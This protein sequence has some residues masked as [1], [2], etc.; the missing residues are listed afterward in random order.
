MHRVRVA[1]RAAPGART[2][3]PRPRAAAVDRIADQRMAD[4]L[5]VDA[6][7]VRAPGFEAAFDQAP[8]LRRSARARGSW[9]APPCRAASTA[10]RVRAPGRGRSARRSRR[11]PAARRAPARGRCASRC[12]R[13]AAHE[14]GLRGRGSSRPP[15]GRSC[16]CPADARC[17]RA[18]PGAAP[19]RACSSAFSSV[20]SGLPAPGCTTS[21]AGLSM[22]IRS[23]SSY[24]IVERHALRRR[25]RARRR[26]RRRERDLLAAHGLRAR[27][28]RCAPSTRTWPGL[29]PCLQP[30][31]RILRETARQR[32][33]QAQAGELRAGTAQ[34]SSAHRQYNFAP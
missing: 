17:R 12:A 2:R 22:T 9:C 34:P 31:A 16:P 21:P 30:A 13:R 33:V 10:M 5:Q 6:D 1:R 27:A 26:R 19:A 8:H 18:A 32:L 25:R 4:V 7:L 23:S 20:P 29:Q 28:R 11:A 14:V 15:A 24:T 3:A